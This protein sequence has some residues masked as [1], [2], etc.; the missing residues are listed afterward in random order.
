MSGRLVGKKITILS[1]RV[2]TSEIKILIIEVKKLVPFLV[3]Q[4]T[5]KAVQ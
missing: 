5:I 3:Y 1:F 2:G 4:F